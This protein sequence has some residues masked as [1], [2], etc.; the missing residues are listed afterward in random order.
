VLNDGRLVG[1]WR[2]R[3][4]EISVEPLE[5]IPP[6]PLAEEIDRVLALRGG[7]KPPAAP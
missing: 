5:P 7:R 4:S 3:K 2:A 1:L 6:Q